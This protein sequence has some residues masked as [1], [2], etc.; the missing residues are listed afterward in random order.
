M[1]VASFPVERFLFGNEHWRS[2]HAIDEMG[3]YCDLLENLQKRI[4]SLEAPGRDEGVTLVNVQA[5]ISSYAME[6]GMKS[7][8]ALDNSPKPVPHRHDLTV[9]FDGLRDETVK[10]LQQLQLTRK[11]LE[12]WPAPFLSNRYS[13]EPGNREVTVYKAPFLRS[14]MQV[15]RDRVEETREALFKPPPTT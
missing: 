6:I 5:V 1:R 13:M 11:D 10:S 4:D 9:L 7:L 3:V 8:W 12:R 14:L 2:Y 15:V